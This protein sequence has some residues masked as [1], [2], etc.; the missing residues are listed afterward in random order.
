MTTIISTQR[1]T[2]E[3][4]AD[5]RENKSQTAEQQKDIVIINGI[6]PI[7]VSTRLAKI[8]WVIKGESKVFFENDEVSAVVCDNASVECRGERNIITTTGNGRLKVLKDPF[9]ELHVEGHSFA[10]VYG[11]GNVNC[12]DNGNVQ[13]HGSFSITARHS[14]RIQ[15]YGCSKVEVYGCGSLD[16]FGRSRIFVNGSMAT[17]GFSG[18]T[19][20]VVLHNE[21]TIGFKDFSFNHPVCRLLDASRFMDEEEDDFIRDEQDSSSEIKEKEPEV[22]T[23]LILLRRH[24]F[25]LTYRVTRKPRNISKSRI[26]DVLSEFAKRLQQEFKFQESLPPV[27]DIE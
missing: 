8:V 15:C 17:M 1:K 25:S 21:S 23:D 6:E 16:A 14:C 3:Y 20:P 2:E 7:Y 9:L 10:I 19:P 24:Y 13:A 22:W 11:S 26:T 12:Q 18:T 4:E 27:E 5:H